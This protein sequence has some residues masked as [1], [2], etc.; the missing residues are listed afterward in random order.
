MIVSVNDEIYIAQWEH[1]KWLVLSSGFLLIPATYA[2]IHKL[3]SFCI[4]LFFTSLISANY[5]RKA[6]YSCRRTLDLL[7]AKISFVVFF[8]NGVLYVRTLHYV[9]PG[10]AGAIMLLYFYYLSGKLYEMQLSNVQKTWFKYHF[11]FHFIIAYEQLIIL[12]SMINAS[13]SE[14]DAKVDV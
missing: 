12:D 3:Y 10:Y 14:L 8:S 11:M 2:Y 6:T 5:W 4:L 1:T 9:I 7:F 13:V